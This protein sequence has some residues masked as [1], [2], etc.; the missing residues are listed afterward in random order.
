[1][2]SLLPII[3]HH[4]PQKHGV[5]TT[6]RSLLGKRSPVVLFLVQPFSP[7]SASSLDRRSQTIDQAIYAILLL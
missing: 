4:G 7:P 6:S 2:H 1:M 3:P 5:G